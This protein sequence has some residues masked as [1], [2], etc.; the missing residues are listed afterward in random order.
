MARVVIA[1]ADV[2]G[3]RMAGPGIRAWHFARELARHHDLALVARF[4]EAADDSFA[5]IEWGTSEARRAMKDAA[6]LIA[7]PTRE[8][9]SL[10]HARAIYDLFDP[11]VLELDELVRRRKSVRLRVKRS[12]EW[13]RLGL[14][15]T[16]GW[17]L[18]HATPRQRDFYLGVHASRNGLLE[19]WDSRWIEIPFGIDAV[20][21]RVETA[22]LPGPPVIVW[23][24]GLWDWLDPDLAIASIERANAEG[25]PA[26]LLFLGARHPN[27]EVEREVGIPPGA[28]M[29]LVIRNGQWIPFHE[30]QRWLEGCR[31]SIMLHH[32]TP[33]AEMAI[34]TRLFDSMAFGLPAIAS[35]G[36]WAATLVEEEGLG[37][38]V[39]TES[40]E[41]VTAAIRKLVEDDAFHASCVMN[42]ERVR[43][44][45]A[46][47]SVVQPLL[48]AIDE[49]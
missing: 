7:Q 11:I 30:R 25:T 46:W 18:I 40:V 2:I 29:P 9:L 16:R 35:R 13:G 8:A 15:L 12:I 32:E 19:G 48:A 36:G 43:L 24:G 14:A 34:R 10:N 23:G 28:S 22:I 39:E 33:E 31:A 42:L 49:A 17:R 47:R 1:T 38:V 26:R 6:V 27:E 3:K 45:F 5:H 37:I 4:R 44:R 20:T 21:E 41:S